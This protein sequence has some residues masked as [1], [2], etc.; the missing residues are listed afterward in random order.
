MKEVGS[1]RRRGVAGEAREGL[2]RNG[3]GLPGRTVPL[4]GYLPVYLPGGLAFVAS[5]GG[6]LLKVARF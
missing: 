2:V 1:R 3:S 5:L 6:R 4:P